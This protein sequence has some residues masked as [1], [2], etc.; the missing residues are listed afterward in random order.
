VNRRPSFRQA[1]ESGR[2]T[3][4]EEAVQQALSLWEERER[5]PIEILGALEE[6]EADLK[7]GQYSDYTDE[8]LPRLAKPLKDEARALGDR[9]PGK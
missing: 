1:I 9:Q 4:V 3:R 8:T 7:T 6:A 2:L 5:K